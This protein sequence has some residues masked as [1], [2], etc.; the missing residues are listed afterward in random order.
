ME[1]YTAPEF[2]FSLLDLTTLESTDTQDKVR[3]LT[4][5]VAELHRLT[6]GRV[7]PAAVCTYP[8]FAALV[9]EGLKGLP[10]QAAVVSGGFPSG[11]T[12]PEMKAAETSMA[13]EAGAQEIDMVINRGRFLAGDLDHTFDEIIAVRHACKGLGL[14]VIIESG[15]LPGPAAIESAA[16]IAIKAGADFVKTSTGK[17]AVSATPE[18]AGAICNAIAEAHRTTGRH[19]GIKLS[20][21]IA[22]YE[23]AVAYIRLVHERLGAEWM[24]PSLL[25]IGASRLAN[26]LLQ[27][28]GVGELR[29]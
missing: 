7:H 2:V 26:D 6:A 1:P 9:R 20:G 28:M 13:V 10:V 8:V 29:F 5:K 23:D 15:E 27:R 16:E 24:T 22:T 18:A 14:K 17:S 21:G 19:T 25:R 3:Q 11:Q 12:F 4:A